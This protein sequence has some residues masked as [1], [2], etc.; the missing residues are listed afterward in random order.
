MVHDH[1]GDQEEEII[2]KGYI[3]VRNGY[4]K[5]RNDS[6]FWCSFLYQWLYFTR[7]QGVVNKDSLG[8][9]IP[10]LKFCESEEENKYLSG[11]GDLLLCT[12]SRTYSLL[13]LWIT[14]GLWCEIF[15]LLLSED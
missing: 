3:K 5:D 15:V 14:G 12:A 7:N 11:R 9:K 2:M 8:V 13:F 6:Y 1:M 10:W 4:E